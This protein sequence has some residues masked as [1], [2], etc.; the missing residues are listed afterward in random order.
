MPSKHIYIFFFL[1]IGSLTAF[2]QVEFT[3]HLSKHKL[4][5]NER[6]RVE[7]KMNKNGDNFTPPDFKGFD[8][9]GGPG[10]VMGNSWVN[11]VRSF[12][13]TYTYYLKPKKRGTLTI[14]QATVEIDGKIYKTSP[15][16][17]EVTAA[18][19]NPT[20]GNNQ[21]IVDVSKGIHVVAL[22]SNKHPYL[23]Q[24]IT[25]TY[26]LYV[27]KQQSVSNWQFVD[28]PEFSNF[29]NNDLKVTNKVKYGSY[30]GDKDY[31]YVDLKK[32]VL[33]P[34]K[35][36]ELTI[37]PLS[38]NLS[39]EVPT[40]RRDVFGRPVYKPL[41]KSFS[42][43]NHTIEVK[44]LPES[45]KPAGFSGAV[46]QFD[47]EMSASKSSL[48]VGAS[49]DVTLTVSGTGNLKLFS[50]PKLVAPQAFE[51]YDPESEQSVNTTASGMR[52]KITDTY[53]MVA[54]TE[55]KYTIDGVQFSY[56]DPTSKSYK[57]I[58]SKPIS[59]TVEGGA[60]ASAGGTNTQSSAQTGAILNH[61]QT[62]QT[63]GKHLR[64]IKLDTQLQPI[65]QSPFFKSPLFWS[66]FALPF[67]LLPVVIGVG[68]NRIK[69]AGDTYG[70]ALRSADKLA[71]KYLSEAKKAMGNQKAYYEALERALHNFLRAKLEIQTAEM[72]K[73]RIVELLKEKQVSAETGQA[74]ISLL[75][76]CEFARYTPATEGGM[77]QDYDKAAKIISEVDKQL[78][79]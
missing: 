71:R 12:E 61:K 44:P 32:V 27:S 29:W 64:Y 28:V 76:S 49:V 79:A 39:I 77:Q 48:E 54:N 30:D 38:L 47:L 74:F 75:K 72:S 18:V 5:L 57:T 13:M 17:V 34:Q 45:G 53:T 35:T 21:T 52:G 26:R 14:G 67:V 36:G 11:G 68:K 59:L 50:L 63:S 55:G 15:Q 40:N 60:L 25:V 7:F 1:F 66:L 9:Y 73:E 51:V 41:Q 10:V 56:F 43:K 23:N 70:S 58:T 62:V 78:K 20:D 22:I 31:R 24:A 69:R 19:N 37:E 6:L 16:Q 4:G 8:V 3:T 33:Y 65:D 42:S 2:G 46:G